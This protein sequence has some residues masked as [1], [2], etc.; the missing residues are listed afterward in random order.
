[1][2]VHELAELTGREI[3]TFGEVAAAAGSVLPDRPDAAVLA[4]LG[5]D[6]SMLVTRR[7]TLLARSR[8]IP[9]VNTVGAGDALLAGF[10]AATV[11]GLGD[12]ERLARAALWGA[13]AVASETTSFSPNPDFAEHITVTELHTPDDLLSEPG[14][15]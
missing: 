7:G 15:P 1:P 4:S 2:N 11:E 3:R 14:A 12:V 8:D 6:G 10:A 9:M 13:S 5:A